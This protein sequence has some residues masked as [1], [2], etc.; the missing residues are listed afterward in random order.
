MLD[1]KKKKK[2]GVVGVG[3]AIGQITFSI[4]Q[5]AEKDDDDNA[6]KKKKHETREPTRSS[7]I[8]LLKLCVRMIIY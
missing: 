4:C 1:I 3:A 7:K 5:I 8:M 6:M 2:A